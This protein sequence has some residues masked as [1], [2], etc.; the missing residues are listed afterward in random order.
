MMAL[1][2]GERGDRQLTSQQ[3]QLVDARSMAGELH[4]LVSPLSQQF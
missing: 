2:A 4:A 3:Q 1:R